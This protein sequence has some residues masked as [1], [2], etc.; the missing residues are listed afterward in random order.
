ML[1]EKI[2]VGRNP[3]WDLNVVIEIPLGG[4]PVKYEL[5]KAS[6]AMFVDRLLHTAMYYPCHYG[7]IPHTLSDDGDPVDVLVAGRTPVVPGCVMRSRPVGVLLMEDEAGEDE[8]IMCVPV[9]SLHP[10]YRNVTTYR[11]LPQILVDQVAHFFS[12]YKDLEVGKWVR[13]RRWGEPQEATQLIEK[14][15]LRA[16]EQAAQSK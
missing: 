15:I 2:P 4:V 14:S 3:P 9:D 7:F 10:F 16:K 1:I 13:I 8:K 6:G 5:D 12:H 11:D